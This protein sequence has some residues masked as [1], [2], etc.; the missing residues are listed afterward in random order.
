MHN[1]PYA[2]LG[3]PSTR[4]TTI[5]GIRD[6]AVAYQPVVNLVSSKMVGVEAL[7]RPVD[8]GAIGDFISRVGGEHLFN[9]L[10]W[11]VLM[12]G[13]E[14]LAMSADSTFVLAV[15]VSTDQLL[16]DAWVEIATGVDE[17]VRPHIVLEI[18]ESESD[19][20]GVPAAIHTIR[21][22]GYLTA[23]DDFASGWS[24]LSRLAE[25]EFDYVKL[26]RRLIEQVVSSPRHAAVVKGAVNLAHECGATVIAEGVEL[27]GQLKAVTD[28]GADAVQGNIFGSPMSASNILSMVLEAAQRG[29]HMD[30][31]A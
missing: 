24:H 15:N 28:L 6:A 8:G 5:A 7:V 9:I 12:T 3:T 29:T 1:D 10:F 31:L 20:P 14:A 30:T 13:I 23:L 16:D 25:S 2:A 22:L 26:D 4:S 17:A 18:T 21:H 11:K 27:L 19:H